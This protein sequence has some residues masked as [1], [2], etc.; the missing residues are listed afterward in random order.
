MQMADKDAVRLVRKE[1]VRH[2]LDTGETQV[3]VMRGLVHLYG[4]VRPLAGHEADF[5]AE[6][7]ALYKALKSHPDIRDVIL[8]WD[9]PNLNGINTKK[10]TN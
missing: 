8:E 7:N 1:L 4:R 6:V 5:D 10:K 9:A 2:A 3:S